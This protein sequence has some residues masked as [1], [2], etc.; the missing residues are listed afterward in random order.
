MVE[1]IFAYTSVKFLALKVIYKK[2]IIITE[3]NIK[4]PEKSNFNLKIMA[5]SKYVG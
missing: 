2:N 4:S 3:V 1:C 5:I